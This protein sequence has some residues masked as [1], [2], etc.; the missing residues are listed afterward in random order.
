MAVRQQ[1]DLFL[2]EVD[3]VLTEIPALLRS[4]HVDVERILLSAEWLLRDVLLI[5]ELLPRPHG[6][7]LV[8]AVSD[9]VASVQEEADRRKLVRRRGRPTIDIPKDQLAMLLEHHFT[10]ADIARMMSVSAR[11]IRRRVLQYGLETST[12][13]SALSDT[14][15][16]EITVPFVH[17]NPYSGRVSYLGFLH[18]AGLRIQQ[19]RVRESLSRVDQRG[20]ERRF[21]QALHR[22]QYSVCMPN[23][24]WHI[25]GHHKLIRWRVVVHGGIDGYSRLVDFLSAQACSSAG[26]LLLPSSLY[27]TKNRPFRSSET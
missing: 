13:F 11:T 1:I 12:S 6:D 19:S 3:A 21:R 10:M 17:T 18:S 22:R 9:V 27:F 5:D 14:Q 16:D 26:R 2:G 23:S 20:M 25:D 4:V 24:L 7:D 15:L 8:T